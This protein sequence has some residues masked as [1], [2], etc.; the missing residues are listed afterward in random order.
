MKKKVTLVIIFVTL[1]V[2]LSI[3]YNNY[4]NSGNKT[5]L[6]SEGIVFGNASAKI[7][8]YFFTS[9]SCN[10]C[11][12]LSANLCEEIKSLLD[13]NEV[14]LIYKVTDDYVYK[15]SNDK[16]YDYDFITK[17]YENW[18]TNALI[19]NSDTLD[20]AEIEKR[21]IVKSTIEKEMESNDIEGVPVFFINDDKYNGL[22]SEEEIET[23]LSKYK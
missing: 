1:L 9:F 7:K 4:C 12:Q 3:Y 22:Y 16:F 19:D 21:K 23:I 6:S 2:I 8:I 5:P 10:K 11:K 20:T 15:W 13:N 17:G 18:V 14:Q